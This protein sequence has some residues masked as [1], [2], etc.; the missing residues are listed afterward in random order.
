[1]ICHKPN[2]LR[3]LNKSQGSLK[4]DIKSVHISQKILSINLR[5]CLGGKNITKLRSTQI[6]AEILTHLDNLVEEPF[7]ITVVSLEI[8]LW[9]LKFTL[10]SQARSFWDLWYLLV[11]YFS[12]RIYNTY[13][14]VKFKWVAICYVISVE[15]GWAPFPQITSFATYKW[16]QNMN[17][18]G[19][20]PWV[21]KII[22]IF[23]LFFYQLTK[24]L[25][26]LNLVLV[27]IKWYAGK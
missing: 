5:T 12:N 10:I 14:S 3:K 2:I 23:V 17:I 1:M 18:W 4:C 24:Y 7:Y 27:Y 26:V 19:S 13:L 25:L 15:S 22:S 8:T 6:E 9:I 21:L 16:A 11:I 20:S